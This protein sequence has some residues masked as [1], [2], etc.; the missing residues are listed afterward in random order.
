MSNIYGTAKYFVS[1]KDLSQFDWEEKSISFKTLEYTKALARNWICLCC[2][3]GTFTIAQA[4]RGLMALIRIPEDAEY[5]EWKL[6]VV[7]DAGE[8]IVR[9]HHFSQGFLQ[10]REEL[11]GLSTETLKRNYL[12]A[13]NVMPPRSFTFPQE[14]NLESP[15]SLIDNK[16]HCA[17]KKNAITPS[18]LTRIPHDIPQEH[19]P[20]KRK[21]LPRS[22]RNKRNKERKKIFLHN[23]EVMAMR[24]TLFT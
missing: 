12:Y 20:K 4:A 24:L 18:K 16:L 8:S 14:Y 13:V 7:C 6:I 3:S 23:F 1:D 5:K 17:I 22:L 21:A 19:Q 15:A 2:R 11:R 10:K 9:F